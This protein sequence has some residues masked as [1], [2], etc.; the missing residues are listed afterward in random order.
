[1]EVKSGKRE[2]G[3]RLTEEGREKRGVKRNPKGKKKASLRGLEDSH[4]ERETLIEEREL[5]YNII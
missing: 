3:Y 1:M 4:E 2:T 5:I